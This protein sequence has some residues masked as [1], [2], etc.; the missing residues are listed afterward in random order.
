MKRIKNNNTKMMIKLDTINKLN[1]CK[2]MKLTKKLYEALK[3]K[4]IKIKKI[5]TKFKTNSYRRI[6]LNFYRLNTNT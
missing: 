1:K 6:Q 5:K 4:Q 2:E 3:S